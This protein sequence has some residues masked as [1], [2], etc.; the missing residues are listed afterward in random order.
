M[1][2][3][4]HLIGNTCR[5]GMPDGIAG[6]HGL[7]SGEPQDAFCCLLMDHKSDELVNNKKAAPLPGAAF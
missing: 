1:G 5:P 2:P 3:F 6:V 7:I 4:S